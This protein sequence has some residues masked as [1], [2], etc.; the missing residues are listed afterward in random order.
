MTSGL[1]LAVLS[2]VLL[3]AGIALLVRQLRPAPPDLSSALA[4]LHEDAPPR[5]ADAEGGRP[6]PVARLGAALSRLSWV[7]FPEREMD[8]MELP[9]ERFLVQKAGFA[10]IGLVLP[11]VLALIWLV[12]GFGTP[13]QVPLVAGLGLAAALW[14]LPDLIVRSQAAERRVEFLHAIAAYMELVA[15]ERAAD[16]GPGEALERAAQVG[17]GPAF[18]R[19]RDALE[20]ARL[21]REPAWQGLERLAQDL[22]LTPLE[23]MAATMR[24]SGTDGAAVYDGLRARARSLRGELLADDLAQANTDSE[25]MVAPGALLVM[26]LVA[27]LAFPALYTMLVSS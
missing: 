13:P 26:L 25:R 20:R 8:L 21:A 15:L 23:D 12:A 24:I 6:D 2:G 7:R 11:S 3:G 5:R 17:S 27:G 16:A 1:W 9:R 10:L 14:F 19:I 22:A 18:G 4:R